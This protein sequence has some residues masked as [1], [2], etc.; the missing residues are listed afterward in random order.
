MGF[1]HVQFR[2]YLGKLRLAKAAGYKVVFLAVF[3]PLDVA[4]RQAMERAKKSRRFA[5]PDRLPES[6]RGFRAC[7]QD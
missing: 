7:W 1:V 3:T 4:I 2:P 5:H 6:H